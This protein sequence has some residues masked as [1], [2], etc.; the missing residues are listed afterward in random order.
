MDL[1]FAISEI[2][3]MIEES[4]NIVFFG[5]AGVSTESGI[6]DFRSSDGIYMMDYKYPPEKIVSRNF[7]NKHPAEFFEFY[8]NYLCYPDVEPNVAHY[9]LAE[10]EAAGKL[11]AIVTQ[12]VDE[13]HAMAGS[14]NIIKLHGDAKINYCTKCGKLHDFDFVYK[15]EG[16]PRCECGGIVRPDLVLFDEDLNL[17]TYKAAEKAIS[18]ADMLIV[19]GT[20]MS[21][22]PAVNLIKKF[23]GLN[24]VLINRD[25]C[26][27]ERRFLL[28][29]RENLGKVM[30]KIIIPDQEQKK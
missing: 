25:Y 14:K 29:V 18:E 22:Y 15:S 13:L 23:R 4:N 16:V 6:P 27:N 24:S 8:R 2:N 11:K 1:N 19:A 3:K 28:S 7:F 9:K 5:G 30:E 17:E 10:L 21:V 20:S 12:N 26:S